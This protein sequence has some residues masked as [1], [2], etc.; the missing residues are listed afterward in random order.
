MP[1]TSSPDREALHDRAGERRFGA[2]VDH[3]APAEAPEDVQGRCSSGRSCREPDLRR[4]DPRGASRAGLHGPAGTGERVAAGAVDE[5]LAPAGTA[6]NKPLTRVVRPTPLSPTRP[7]IS[8]P[9][10][11][12]G[13]GRG[14]PGDAEVAH[15]EARRAGWIAAGRKDL[16][17]LATDHHP[18][19]VVPVDLGDRAGAGDQAVLEHRVAVAD[20][21]HLVESVTDVEHGDTVTF[22]ASRPPRRAARARLRTGRPTARP[23]R[24]RR[25]RSTTPW[26]SRRSGTL[27]TLRL[28]TT[29]RGE[30]ELPRRSSR[31]GRLGDHPPTVDQA[32]AV[33]LAPEEHVL[34]DRHAAARARAPGG[35]RRRR[36]A[37]SDR[38]EAVERHR[39]RR[40]AS[41]S[42]S[43]E[44][45]R[46]T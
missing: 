24:R 6:P 43:S 37:G 40:A 29:A 41:S 7:T 1:S 30:I 8:P 39:R 15:L 17:D 28:S 4:G 25:R 14:E 44:R 32:D 34:G 13:H 16:G 26:R 45:R 10:T 46:R 20:R 21:E 3:T 12:E 5:D 9:A 22:E 2:L 23:W 31:T 33:E 42:R 18:D 11:C 19:E 38:V 36:G 35:P 27:A